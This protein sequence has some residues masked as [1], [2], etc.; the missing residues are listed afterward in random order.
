MGVGSKIILVKLNYFRKKN[1]FILSG[2]LLNGYLSNIK[3]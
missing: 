2:K 3:F 1:Y